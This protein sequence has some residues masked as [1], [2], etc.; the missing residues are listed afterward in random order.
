M[1]SA[2]NE[3]TSEIGAARAMSETPPRLVE[4]RHVVHVSGFEPIGPEG[5]DRR[6]KSGLRKFG[7]LWGATA[8]A[9]APAV[10]ADGRSVTWEVTTRGP[11]WSTACRYTVLR[12]DHLMAPYVERPWAARILHGY[13]ALAEFAVTGTIFRY[14][15]A[16]IRY[17]LFV[18]YPVLILLGV[19][20]LGVLAGIAAARLGV[21]FA[22]ASAPLVG[23]A[24]FIVLLRLVGSYFYLDFALADWAFAADLA[25]RDIAGLEETL[26]QFAGEVSRA[27]RDPEADEVLLS[28]VSLGAVMLVESLARAY[29]TEPDLARHAGK[30]AFLSVGSS[31][32]KIGLHPAASGLRRDVGRIGAEPSLAW[33]EF[34]AKVDPINFYKTDP[35]ADLGMAP[36]GK[37]IV[38]QIRIRDMM[39]AAGYRKA[40]RSSLLL[41]RQFVM[42]NAKRYFY[43]F[44]QISFG[45]LAL[46][47]RIGLGQKAASVFAE[48]GSYHADRTIAGRRAA[49]AAGE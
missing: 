5:L 46:A 49:M 2:K 41:H 14:F 30:T 47:R 13:K 23:I 11:N 38:R 22:A 31:I 48:D 29:A 24:A 16:N 18:I 35:V 25:R 15:K 44:Y 28:S 43:D 45:P 7:E 42:P 36:T 9:S 3:P 20:L 8:S 1:I 12:W 6:M 17:G 10:A 33:V 19:V 26:A 32:L 34:Q 21:P 4:R 27:M 40:Q 37:P 39:T